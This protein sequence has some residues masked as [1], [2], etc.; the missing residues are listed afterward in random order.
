M[1]R[2]TRSKTESPEQEKPVVLDMAAPRTIKIKTLDR[3]GNGGYQTHEVTYFRDGKYIPESMKLLDYIL[4]DWRAGKARPYGEGFYDAIWQ[5]T[6]NL[7][8]E[9]PVVTSAFRTQK[10]LDTLTRQGYPTYEKSYHVHGS[11]ID[12]SGLPRG[13]LTQAAK[14][15]RSPYKQPDS[16]YH[17]GHYHFSLNAPLRSGE[18]DYKPD[19]NFIAL[20]RNSS[21]TIAYNGINSLRIATEKAGE[22]VAATGE[23]IKKLVPFFEGHPGLPASPHAASAAAAPAA[24]PTVASAAATPRLVS[25]PKPITRADYEKTK[26]SIAVPGARQ[27]SER[28][29]ALKEN[30]SAVDPAKRLAEQKQKAAERRRRQQL[31]ARKAGRMARQAAYRKRQQQA[32]QPWNPFQ[33]VG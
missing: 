21:G 7:K 24:T 16:V 3:Q 5:F 30:S 31:A 17:F 23:S 14:K 1:A 8:G 12:F 27:N 4:H 9:V 2:R 11:A 22:V 33:V 6:K 25:Q 20:H 18:K 32:A 26:S 10:T 15:V 29:S 19:E 13:L 28:Y